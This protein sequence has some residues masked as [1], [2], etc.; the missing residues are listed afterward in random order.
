L[1]DTLASNS[2]DATLL[3]D[4]FL[5]V[6]L[7]ANKSLLHHSIHKVPTTMRIQCNAGVTTTNLK[8][9][10]GDFPEPVWYNLGGVA[11]IL[12]LVFIVKKY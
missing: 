10:L 8:G 6:N 7:I 11:N 1:S 4:S 9:W 5:T 12:S 2:T 3:L